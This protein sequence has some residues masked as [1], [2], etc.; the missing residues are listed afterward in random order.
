MMSKPAARRDHGARERRPRQGDRERDRL[1]HAVAS[2]KNVDPI[3]DSPYKPALATSAVARPAA[4]QQ[5]PRQVAALLCGLPKSQ[6]RFLVFC[7]ERA[8]FGHLVDVEFD[9]LRLPGKKF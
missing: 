5:A 9:S 1:T 8:A 4:P 6:Q 2:P 3:F 7:P